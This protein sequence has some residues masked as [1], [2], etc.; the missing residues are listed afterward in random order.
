MY[1]KNMDFVVVAPRTY[2]NNYLNYFVINFLVF[3]FIISFEFQFNTKYII[4]ILIYFCKTIFGKKLN[5]ENFISL[6]KMKS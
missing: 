2:H 5:V 3:V 1:L 6:F 4:N